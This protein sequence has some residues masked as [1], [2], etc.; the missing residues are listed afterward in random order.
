MKENDDHARLRLATRDGELVSDSSGYRSGRRRWRDTPETASTD[1]TLSAGTTPRASQL[2][3]VLCAPKP[4]SRAKA[5]C[6]PTASH[7]SSSG[8]RGSSGAAG[9][10]G[11]FRMMAAINAQ[12]VKSVNAETVNRVLHSVRMGRQAQ[13]EPSPFWRR[14]TE[15]FAEQG[16][17]T[18]QNGIATLLD[19]SQGS[20][21]RWFHG[22]GSPELDTARDLARRGRVCIDW[23]LDAVKP[24]Y[25]ISRD[26]VLRELFAVCE[27][28]QH[29]GRDRV[30]RVA[31][32]E[33]IQQ[34]S[35]KADEKA[36]I[37]RERTA[38]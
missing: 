19:M 22:E 34:Q 29:E 33:L 1:S 9:L 3:T 13:S 37:P 27:D 2:D 18:T 11:S 16:L 17:P 23:L 30:L 5:V 8:V 7:A 12:T 26:P 10:L 28:L 20:V 21:G 35:E 4:S 24:K 15:A 38:R 14:L 25:P 31:R 32:G 36:R 6:P